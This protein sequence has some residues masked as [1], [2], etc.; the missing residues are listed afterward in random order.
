MSNEIEMER[1]GLISIKI[2]AQVNFVSI[3]TGFFL[4]HFYHLSVILHFCLGIYDKFASAFA[5]AVRALE[6]GNGLIETTVQ[7]LTSILKQIHS[8]NIHVPRSK[9]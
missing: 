7:V 4:F 2:L 6:V 9:V 8:F 5:K 1:L 3:C